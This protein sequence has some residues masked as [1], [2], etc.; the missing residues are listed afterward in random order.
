MPAVKIK[1][2]GM[3][4]TS[5][6]PKAAFWMM[7]RVVSSK[8]PMLSLRSFGLFA[9]AARPRLHIVEAADVDGRRAGRNRLIGPIGVV[10]DLELF[11]IDAADAADAPVIRRAHAEFVA[12]VGVLLGFLPGGGRRV[13][14][15]GGG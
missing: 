11:P 6:E 2:F 1:V 9:V 15:A 7:V 12:L 4:S 13:A 3:I 10:V 14:F 8:N 5:T